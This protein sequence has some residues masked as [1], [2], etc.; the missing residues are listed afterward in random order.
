MDSVEERK[1]QDK[2]ENKPEGRVS[3]EFVKVTISRKAE[4][5]VMDLLAKVNDGFEGGR[6]TRQ[7]LMSWI[8]EKFAEGCGEPEVRAIRVDHF[9]EITI[10]ELCLKKSKQTGSL[11][12]ELR[13]LLLAQAGMDDT[14]KRPSKNKLTKNS[15]N[16]GVEKD[17]A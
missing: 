4:Q 8:L 13:K 10:L 6:V 5:I 9:D 17:V 15:I 16:D 12:P 1:N 3:E 14:A 11:P 7:D 2:T